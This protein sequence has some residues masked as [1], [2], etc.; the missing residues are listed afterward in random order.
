MATFSACL[1]YFTGMKSEV[2]S[3]LGVVSLSSSS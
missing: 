3:T 1:V 2:K